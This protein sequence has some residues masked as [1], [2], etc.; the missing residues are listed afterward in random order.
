MTRSKQTP[1]TNIVIRAFRAEDAV[2]VADVVL[3]A[4]T[5][6]LEGK[7]AE[8]ILAALGDPARYQPSGPTSA[9]Y[10]A[11]DEGEIVGYVSG[12]ASPFGFGTLSVIGVKASHFG[13]GVGTR[14]MKRM[15]TFWRRKKMRKV[16]TCVSGHNSRALV[17]YLKNGFTPVGCQRDHFMEGVDEVILDR[18][19]V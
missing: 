13:H 6:F 8:R 3:E 18:F 10:V 1:E 12:S 15:V 17:F 16:T 19:L 4:F 14:L 7:P 2:A 9:V 11:E 5:S